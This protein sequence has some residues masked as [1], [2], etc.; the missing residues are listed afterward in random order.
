MLKRIGT[1]KKAS[2]LSETFGNLA[3]SARPVESD[4]KLRRDHDT[5]T[6]YSSEGAEA[7]G[8]L[9]VKQEIV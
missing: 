8:T 2:A 5:D 3:G 4:E 7:V 1:E 6:C 9:S